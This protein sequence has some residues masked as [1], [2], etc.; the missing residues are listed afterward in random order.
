M[1]KRNEYTGKEVAEI[2]GRLLVASKNF[3]RGQ[4]IVF[5]A[6]RGENNFI[7]LAESIVAMAASLV[8]QAADKKPARRKRAP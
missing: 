6:K 2:A 3:R 4:F 1:T 7:L 5:E 8:T